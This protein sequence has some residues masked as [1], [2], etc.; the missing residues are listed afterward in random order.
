[1]S[2]IKQ[3][4]FAFF[5]ISHIHCANKDVD[6]E[7]NGIDEKEFIAVLDK[8]NESFKE[9]DLETLNAMVADNYVHTNGNSKSIGKADWFNYLESRKKDLESG[10]LEVLEYKMDETAIEFYDNLAIVTAKIS[11]ENKKQDTVQ[12]NEYRVTN[13]WV[14]ENGIW[15][16]AGF[17]DGKIK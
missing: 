15:K 12:N 6:A 2:H 14:K 16:R 1:M 5:I 4:A 7:T 17:H 8:F 3:I 13:I 11:V 10:N 9:C